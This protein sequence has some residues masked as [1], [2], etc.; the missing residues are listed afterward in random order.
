MN[1][2]GIFTGGDL[3]RQSRDWLQER[4]GKAGIWYHG[5]SRGMDDR[6]VIADRPRKSSGSEKTR[7]EEHTSEHQSLMRISYDVFRLKKKN[8]NNY[9]HDTNIRHKN[10]HHS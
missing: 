5:I 8:T 9:I 7:S 3:R 1:R 2:L 10:K 4:F 6:P